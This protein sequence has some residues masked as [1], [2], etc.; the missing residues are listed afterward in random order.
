MNAIPQ[1]GDIFDRAGESWWHTD[2][3][4]VDHAD[5]TRTEPTP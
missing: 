5:I 4:G 3:F 2:A 1:I